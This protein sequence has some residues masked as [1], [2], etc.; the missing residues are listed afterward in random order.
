MKRS[1]LP[2]YTCIAVWAGWLW[3]S[4]A[5]TTPRRVESEM[6]DAGVAP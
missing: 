1:R 2:L 3:A 4:H 5:W 6:F